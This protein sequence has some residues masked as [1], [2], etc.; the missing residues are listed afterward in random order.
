MLFNSFAFLLFLPLA[1]MAY[2]GLAKAS[3][4][5]QNAFVLLASY[6]FYGW[7]D[8]RFLGLLFVSSLADYSIGLAMDGV[9]AKFQRKALLLLSIAINLGLLAFF[10]Y[11]N[12]FIEGFGDLLSLFGLQANVPTLRI[13][14]P[15]GISFY[16]FQ[17][18]SY[19]IDIYRGQVRPT[20]DPIAFFAF[21]SFFPQLV[22]GPIERARDLLPQFLVHRAFD[23]PSARDG[24]RR[25]LWGLFKKVAIA[26]TCAPVVNTI[27]ALDPSEVSGITLF[28]G[29]FF[30]AF[31]IYGDFSGYSDIAIGTARLFGFR[32]S[33]NFA[34]PYFSRSISEFWRRWHISLS[35]W[36]RDYVYIPLGG[37]R[38]R[39]GRTRNILITFAVSGLWHGANWTFLGW[40]MVH[41]LYHLPAVFA[42]ARA[43]REKA[44]LR[45]LPAM[46]ATFLLVTL[47]WVLFRAATL[48][49][50]LRYLQYMLA[51]AP[52]HPGSVLLYVWRGEMLLIAFMLW[53]EWRN[54]EHAHALEHLSL[55]TAMRWAIY[56]L[57]VI[58]IMLNLDLRNVHEFI[59]F[60]F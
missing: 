40:G 50:A 22:A 2:W 33:Q 45:D 5:A 17:T 35:T 28:F 29:A 4:R 39:M 23:M 16:T 38:D 14:L 56:F 15:V 34:Y 51:N 60:R 9:Q 8:W 46:V 41:G 13:I 48:M 59:Y 11:F 52:L 49:D 26:D 47:A 18:L 32:L 30:F 12:F 55:G 1:Y 44:T 19:T 3:V 42:D 24:L 31:Q 7:W 37:W 21:V 36:F 58:T 25:I 6:L 20:R 43:S 10:K 27:F 53:A 54:R 57:L